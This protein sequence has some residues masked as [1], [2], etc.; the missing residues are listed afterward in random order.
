MGGG[1]GQSHMIQPV[2]QAQ[3]FIFVNRK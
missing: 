3:R 1:G 2:G